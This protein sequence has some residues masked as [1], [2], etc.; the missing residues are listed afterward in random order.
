MMDG[1][2]P[3]T[4]PHDDDTR[5]IMIGLVVVIV[6]GI[7]YAI[8]R[9]QTPTPAIDTAASSIKQACVRTCDDGSTTSVVMQL[10]PG[11][12]IYS[13]AE[14]ICLAHGTSLACARC[15]CAVSPG[16]EFNALSPVAGSQQVSCTISQNSPEEDI[17]IACGVTVT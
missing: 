10:L 17:A 9:P 16:Q 14:A 8:L 5:I 7:L 3:R 12:R 1:V 4:G 13:T 15:P 2:N 11:T 6:L